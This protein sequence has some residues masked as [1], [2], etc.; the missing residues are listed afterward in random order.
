MA[1]VQRFMLT[2]SCLRCAA[3]ESLKDPDCMARP[4]LV[5]FS[6]PGL[7]WHNCNHHTPEAASAQAVAYPAQA[8]NGKEAHACRGQL[9]HKVNA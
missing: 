4:L 8:C 1:L 9:L 7:L 3:S 6:P 2:A 5:T